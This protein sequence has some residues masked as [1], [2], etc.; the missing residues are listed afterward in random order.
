MDALITTFSH[1]RPKSVNTKGF[2]TEGKT[3]KFIKDG[4]VVKKYTR[5]ETLAPV[6]LWT[7][8][9]SVNFVF[10]SLSS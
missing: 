4:G 10:F 1:R 9:Q 2:F 6:P 5:V 7:D 3:S 8:L